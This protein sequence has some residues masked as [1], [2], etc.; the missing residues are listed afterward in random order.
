MLG[1]LNAFSAERMSGSVDRQ[2][3]VAAA[4]W[5]SACTAAVKFG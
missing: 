4:R 1:D 3:S 2:F 5:N